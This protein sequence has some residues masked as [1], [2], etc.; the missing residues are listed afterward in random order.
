MPIGKVKWYDRDRGFGF[1]SNPDGDD[2]FVGRAVLPDGVDELHKGQRIDYDYA[3]GRRGPQAMHITVLA[4]PQ[5]RDAG[6]ARGGR[7]RGAG[8][9]RR[10]P[11][12]L[13]SM[14]SDVISMLEGVQGELERGRHVERRHGRQVAEVLRA[15]ARDL[16]H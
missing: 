12:E 16:D 1:V 6:R 11:A 10:S 9:A 5:R 8:G 14:I 13:N 2:V 7:G 15:I 3:D 4:E